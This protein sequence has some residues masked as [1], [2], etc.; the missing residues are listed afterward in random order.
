MSMMRNGIVAFADFREG[1]LE[2]IDQI[3]SNIRI[4]DKRY[5]VGRPEFTM[6]YRKILSKS[7]LP[8]DVIELFFRL[9]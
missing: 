5:C 4:I 6:T 7:K 2:G 3:R 1:G 9:Q 8:P